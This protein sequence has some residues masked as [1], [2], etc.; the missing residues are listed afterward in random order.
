MLESRITVIDSRMTDIDRSDKNIIL[1]DGRVVPYDTLVLSMGIQE[2]TLSTLGYVSYGIN[3]LPEGMRRCRGL[4]SI[5]DPYLYRFLAK[6][7]YLMGKLTDRRR[8]TNVVVYGR[9]LN[10]FTLI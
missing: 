6:E 7:E 3:P 10:T 5:D 1:N 4:I 8:Q 2:N 9:S